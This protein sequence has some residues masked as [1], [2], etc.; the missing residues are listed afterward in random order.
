MP[1]RARVSTSATAAITERAT[2]LGRKL[3]D[4]LCKG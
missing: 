1:T 3:I 2:M 4:W